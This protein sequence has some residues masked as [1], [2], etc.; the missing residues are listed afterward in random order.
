LGSRSIAASPPKP[1]P[2]ASETE[3]IAPA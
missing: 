1:R 2:P 3:I